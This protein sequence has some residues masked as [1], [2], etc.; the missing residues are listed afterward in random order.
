MPISSLPAAALGD[1]TKEGRRWRC[2]CPVHGGTSFTIGTG[3]NGKILW[4]C[5][6]G[7]DG[8]EIARELYRLDLLVGDDRRTRPA[9]RPQPR[10]PQPRDDDDAADVAARLDLARW[11]W[12]RRLSLAGTLAYRYLRKT[13]GLTGPFPAPWDSCA[14]TRTIRR[15]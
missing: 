6:S 7:C 2:R 3:K 8:R 4:K 9:D 15:R 1:A 12:R 10:A 5:W 14:P 13:R 11:L